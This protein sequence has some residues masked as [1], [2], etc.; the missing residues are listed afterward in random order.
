MLFTNYD[1]FRDLSNS[2]RSFD[3]DVVRSE[4]GV[5]VR[6]DIPG[7]DPSTVDLTVDGRSLRI[8]TTRPTNV[9]ENAQVVTSRR[10]PLAASQT[11][12][13]GEQLDAERLTADYEFG[14]LTVN[15]PVAE[16]AKPRKV[17][18]GVGTSN[19]TAIDAASE[20]A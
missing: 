7:I 2:A 16:S 4:D 10:R 19:A 12:Q 13:L 1:P 6:I 3:Y 5:V 20:A 11:F 9:P 14:V 17:E 15:I 18:V 8:E